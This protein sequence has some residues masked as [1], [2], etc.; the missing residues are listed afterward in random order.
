MTDPAGSPTSSLGNGAPQDLPIFQ[1]TRVPAG[2]AYEKIN[3]EL[4]RRRASK[5]SGFLPA[6]ENRLAT[7][8]DLFAANLGIK[9][10]NIA[11]ERD[12]SAVDVG[13]IDAAHR[14]IMGNFNPYVQAWRLAVGALTGGGAVAAGVGVL[15]APEPVTHQSF[16]WL[17]ILL[18]VK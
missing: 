11:Y 13:D 6:A 17:V 15:I 5:L 2:L 18:G 3:A 1:A 10:V 16:W 8:T 4:D 14:A 12:A 7:L 9:A